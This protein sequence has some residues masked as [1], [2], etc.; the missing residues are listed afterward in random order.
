MF[1]LMVCY[2]FALSVV[3]TG[4]ESAIDLAGGDHPHEGTAVLIQDLDTPEQEIHEDSGHCS[5]CCHG[6][7]N[8]AMAVLS[9]PRCDFGSNRFASYQP[10]IQTLSQAPPTPPPNA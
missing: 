1:K 2:F 4:F 10:L 9:I 7:A 8:A 5:N 6:H 3:F